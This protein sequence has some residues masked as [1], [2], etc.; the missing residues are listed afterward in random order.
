MFKKFQEKL[1]RLIQNQKPFILFR[2]PNTTQVELWENKAIVTDNQFI[3]NSF[4]NSKLIEFNDDEV[5]VIPIDQ[6]PNFEL[7]L[8]ESDQNEEISYENYI[9]L[10]QKTVQ[11]LRS[12]SATKKIVISR[13]NSLA[14]TAVNLAE[15]FKNLHQHYPNAYLYLRYDVKEGCWI[16]ASPELLLKESNQFI[17]TV[18][19]A[20]TK[21]KE[22]DWTEKEYHEQQVVTDYIAS[23]LKPYTAYIDVDGPF[24]VN[25]GFFEHL[26]SYISAQL[27]D[28]TK[29]Y[30]LLKALHPTPA[31]GGM[32]KDLSK[33]FILKNEGYDR[34][35][36]A[37]FMGYQNK[38]ASEY[39]VNLRCA[40]I[41]S[42]KVNLYVG[43]GIMPDSVPEKEWH[44][45]EL[46]SKTIGE[47]LIYST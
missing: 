31:V 2:K 10:I 8:P 23:T 43:G 6:L 15:T 45:T 14:K 33:D 4:D 44:E 11:E 32:P 18:S 27:N 46:K 1:E 13:I 47:L 40:K 30:D 29:L 21:A 37:G 38:I 20:G 42:N 19:L 7:S 36:Y 5:Q 39:F 9:N 22:D 26:K 3:C 41:Y 35:F 34:S 28:K 16:G 25:A 17:E 12:E 24:S